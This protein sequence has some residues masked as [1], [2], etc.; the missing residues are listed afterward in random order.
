MVLRISAVYFYG[1][2][3]PKMLLYNLRYDKKND[4]CIGAECLDVYAYNGAN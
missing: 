3:I 4:D 2:N 1:F